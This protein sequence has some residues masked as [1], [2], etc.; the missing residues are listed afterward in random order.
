MIPSEPNTK[1]ALNG[2][3]SV[4]HPAFATVLIFLAN[5]ARFPNV[6]TKMGIR[7][8]TEKNG[9]MQMAVMIVIVL[10]VR[11][12]AQRTSALHANTMVRNIMME[13]NSLPEIIVIHVIVIKTMGYI[14]RKIH[15][16]Q[17]QFVILLVV[18]IK[19]VVKDAMDRPSVRLVSPV[20]YRIVTK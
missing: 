8:Q 4:V 14:V 2:S 6:W 12:F 17:I 15:V 3:M 19:N 20:L 13:M 10:I 7:V 1:M 9:M 18:L 11:F 5:P 16:A